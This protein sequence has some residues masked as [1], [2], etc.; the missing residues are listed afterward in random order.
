[1]AS[2]A[3]EELDRRLRRLLELD[4]ARRGD[5]FGA[6]KADEGMM[7]FCQ[8]VKDH[9]ATVPQE[10]QERVLRTLKSLNLKPYWNYC[11]EHLLDLGLTF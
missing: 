4:K 9:K 7:E 2:P 6:R 8:Y 11:R 5:P 10:Q 1:M 3:D